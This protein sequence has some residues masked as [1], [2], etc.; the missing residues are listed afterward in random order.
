MI[1]IVLCILALVGSYLAGR[2]SITAGL[3]VVMAWGYFYGIL[4]ANFATAASHFMFDCSILG[5]YSSQTKI[6]FSTVKR[7]RTLQHW[8]LALVLWPCIVCFF[9]FQPFLVSL[10]GL[11]GN[12]FFL[13][14]LLIGAELTSERV[15]SLARGFAALNLS[16]LGFGIAEYVLGVPKFFPVNAVTRIIYASHDVGGAKY[17]RIPAT[18]YTAHAYGG[19]MVM[20]I[21]LL[22]GLL[23]RRDGGKLD[24]LIG[25]VGLVT[26]LFGILLSS[27]RL[28]FTVAALLCLAILLT[29]DLSVKART[30]M[31][32]VFAV[33][34][35]VAVNNARMNRFQSLNR[36]ETVTDRI[37]G[38]VNASLWD[39]ISQHPMGNGLGGGGTSIP[40]FLAGQVRNPTV[41]ENEFARI[42]LEQ[43]IIG[44]LL[45]LSFLVWFATCSAV[46]QNV[47]WKAGRK[48]AWV[49]AMISWATAFIGTGTLTAIPSAVTLLMLMGWAAAK[50]RPEPAALEREFFVEYLDSP[51]TA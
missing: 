26:A 42:S 16:A 32:V 22:F 27:T 28:H 9:P 45:W 15:T 44:L 11:R 29:N 18:F 49:A 51:V 34:A 17:F 35:L 38:S 4:R 21:P 41:M 47:T 40:Y 33:V 10:V 14:M 50:Q 23:A 7:T 37:G 36:S 2:R 1:A 20:S 6:L 24:K 30:P 48:L 43:G 8:L 31:L 12:I 3:I 46:S 13:P 25:I 39:V 5:F 19:A